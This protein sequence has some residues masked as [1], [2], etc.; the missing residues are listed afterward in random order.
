MA[1]LLDRQVGC[2][3]YQVQPRAG[4]FIVFDKQAPGTAVKH[5][6]YQAAENDEGGTLVAPTVECNLLAGPTSR[7][8]SDFLDTASVQEGLA[9]V[10]E[11]ARKVLPDLKPSQAI[12]NF[13]GIRANITNVPKEAKDFVV[14]MSAS[15]FV[16]A[17]GIK[18]PGM[19][20]A[21]ALAKRAVRLLADE[22]LALRPDPAFDP[23]RKRY[24]PF[25][26]RSAD[27]QRLM[28]ERDPAYGRVICRCEH[29]TEGDIRAVLREPLPPTTL[30]GLKRR[31]RCGMG[32]CQGAFCSP[33]IVSIMACELGVQESDVLAGEWGGRLV[34]RSVK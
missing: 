2:D 20:S 28:L 3:D 23:A 34:Q 5:V 24:V 22:G 6:L 25:L 10:M 1:C 29:I 21:P 4:D 26:L 9:H 32:R 30:A 33:R 19:T 11:V 18:N 7:D 12:R 8:A 13:A 31:L 16:S 27:E 15:G 17:I 14:R